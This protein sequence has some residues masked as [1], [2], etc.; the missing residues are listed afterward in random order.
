MGTFHLTDPDDP[1][2]SLLL[3]PVL[4]HHFHRMNSRFIQGYRS[5][6]SLLTSR[7]QLA[8]STVLG[9]KRVKDKLI[10][11]READSM[12]IKESM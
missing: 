1:I 9:A 12:S 7:T 5:L 4:Y 8:S 6:S 3:E 11:F 2:R 10:G